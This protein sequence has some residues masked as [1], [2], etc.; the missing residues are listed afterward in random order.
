[1]D[2][3]IK[4][5]SLHLGHN[6]CDFYRLRSLLAAHGVSTQHTCFWTAKDQFL[7]PLF[8]IPYTDLCKK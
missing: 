7:V 4:Q 6:I 8:G 1:M 5:I 3:K 2:K